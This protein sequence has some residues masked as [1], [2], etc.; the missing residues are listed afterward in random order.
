MIGV[1]MLRTSVKDLE[2]ILTLSILDEGGQ[3]F[4][5]FLYGRTVERGLGYL[6]KLSEH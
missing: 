4:V 6:G 2:P 1:S 5:E 3:C